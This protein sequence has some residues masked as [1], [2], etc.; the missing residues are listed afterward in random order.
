MIWH[1]FSF[2]DREIFWT[3]NSETNLNSFTDCAL[4]PTSA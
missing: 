3:D 1:F 2:N 4:K